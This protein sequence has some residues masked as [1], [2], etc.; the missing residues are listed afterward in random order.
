MGTAAEHGRRGGRGSLVV[1]VVIVIEIDG[2]RVA[3]RPQ[4]VA[5]D[6]KKRDFAELTAANEL[7]IACVDAAFRARHGDR[8]NALFTWFAPL[9]SPAARADCA[10]V[11]AADVHPHP[12]VRRARPPVGTTGLPAH[13]GETE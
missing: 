10:T 9:L 5:R 2:I 6:Q 1:A 13:G 4:P 3:Q 8:L 12:P 11:P 7:D